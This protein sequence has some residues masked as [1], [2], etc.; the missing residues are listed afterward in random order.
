MFNSAKSLLR[1]AAR[2]RFRVEQAKYRGEEILSPQ[3]G[4]DF[5]REACGSASAFS[6]GKIGAA[7]LGGLMHYKR[8]KD[9]SGYCANWGRHATLL[10]RN[11]GVY[12]REPETFS[13]FCQVYAESL[14]SLDLLAVWFHWGERSV[15]RRN[16][17][18]ARLVSLTGLEPYYH[19]R[20]WSQQLVGKKVLVLTPF[21]RS[22]HSQAGRLKQ[23]WRLKPEVMP[24][25]ELQTLRVPLSAALEKPVHANWFSALEA[26]TQEMASR[27]FD[28]ALVGAGAWSLPLVARAKQMGKWAIHLGGATQILFG[29]NGGRW[30]DN[31]LVAAANN[32]AW[33]RPGEDERPSS[34]RSIEQGCYW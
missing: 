6:A 17:P 4:N 23:V 25:I 12:P 13:R 32:E 15:R 22:V 8:Y 2:Q 30:D 1:V 20:P 10:H 5:L 34:F 27:T 19:S 9:S 14:C 11:A 21:A 16:A 7:E 33:V 31:S 18:N 29:I 26:M 3:A 24:D 28:V